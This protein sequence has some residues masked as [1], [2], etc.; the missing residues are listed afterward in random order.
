MV[1][2]FL[3]IEE[4]A[5]PTEQQNLDLPRIRSLV[6]AQQFIDLHVPPFV[7][8]RHS[9]QSVSIAVSALSE[10]HG[11]DHSFVLVNG[12]ERVFSEKVVRNYQ[13]GR[14]TLHLRSIFLQS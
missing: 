7:L 5:P 3:S 10:T 13:P 2:H 9:L 14:G 12:G 11:K 8:L 1:S 6:S 4:E